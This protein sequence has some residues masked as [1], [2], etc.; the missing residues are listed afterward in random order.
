MRLCD[1][2]IGE[3]ATVCDLLSNGDMRR[4]LLDIGL[5]PGSQVTCVGRSACGDP[6]A[7][8]I[9]GAIIAIRDKDSAEIL[10]K[11]IERSAQV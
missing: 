5:I 3:C 6:A 2:K 8:A 11:S 10:I 9:C 4:R 7:Y 1:L